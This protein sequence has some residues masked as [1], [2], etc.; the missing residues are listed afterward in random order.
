MNFQEMQVTMQIGKS[1]LTEGVIAEIRKQLA[2]KKIVKVKFLRNIIDKNDKQELFD[3]IAAKTS[4]KILGK[5][6]FCVVLKK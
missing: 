4:S 3:Q 2:K 5:V 1:G 6:G